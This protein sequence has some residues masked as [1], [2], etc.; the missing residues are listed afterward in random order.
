[1]YLKCPKQIVK[2]FCIHSQLKLYAIL[3]TDF[4]YHQPI[5]LVRSADKAFR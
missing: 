1:M 2:H 3:I 5:K 4:F